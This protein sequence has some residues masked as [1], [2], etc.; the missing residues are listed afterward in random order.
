MLRRLPDYTCSE[1]ISRSVRISPDVPFRRLDTVRLQVGW[2][3][4]KERYGKASAAGFEDREIRDLVSRGM[5]SNGN[6]AGHVQY[7][8]LSP[9]TEFK[10]RGAV[11]FREREAARYDYDVPVEYSRYKIRGKTSA[12]V[13]VHGSFWFDVK[14]LDLLRMELHA[15]EIPPELGLVRLS[16][17]VDY[18]RRQIGDSEFLLPSASDL[19]VLTLTGDEFR[20][21]TTFTDCRQF[22]AESNLR[23]DL[24]D[25]VETSRPAPPSADR[26]IESVESLPPSLRVDLVL[27]SDIEPAKSAEDAVISATVA[28]PVLISEQVVIP[29]GSIVEGRVVRLDRSSQPFDHW[30]VGLEFHTIVAGKKR[31][32]FF[33]TMQT[34][35]PASGLFRE[36]KRL[37]PVFTRKRNAR[38]DI[39]VREKPHG[40]GILHWDARHPVIRRGLKMSWTT[41]DPVK[42]ARNR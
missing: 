36:A 33:A 34:A 37:D 23:F 39:L 29:A 26:E 2:I 30:V 6:F 40:E 22:R 38:M 17:I 13:G 15:D 32:E 25:A 11:R 41:L 28:K 5:T 9:A 35:G 10:P 20:N 8:I 27:D 16:E 21:Q 14:T 1:T 31:I 12:E 4:G 19:T 24:D 42:S 7:V 3:G 18:D